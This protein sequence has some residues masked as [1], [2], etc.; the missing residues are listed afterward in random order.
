M[1][2]DA[3]YLFAILALS[4]FLSRERFWYYITALKF[5]SFMKVNLK[6]LYSEPRPLFVWSDLSSIGCATT[7]GSPSGHSTMS[8][9]AAALIVLDLFFSSEWGQRKLPELN[10]MTPRSHPISFVLVSLA[11][12]SW[13]LT[14]LFDRVFLGKHTLNQ[15]VL[16]SQLG[17]WCACFQHFVFRDLLFSHINKITSDPAQLARG[18]AIKYCLKATFIICLTILVTFA[19]GFTMNS[20]ATLKQEWLVNLRDTCGEVYEQDE[21]GNL[22]ANQ[23]G[24]YVGSM[25]SF[26]NVMLILGLYIGQVMFRL[27]AGRLCFDSY[28][29]KGSILL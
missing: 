25:I 27:S 23:S 22:I 11:A 3:A 24:L 28:A 19:V 9:C 7:F 13:W 10:K 4:P 2:F 14:T 18:T 17:I 12:V 26:V 1:T 16:G 15:I 5:A 8:S 6:M 21:D 20:A 29:S